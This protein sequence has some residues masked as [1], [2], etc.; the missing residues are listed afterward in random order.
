MQLASGDGPLFS[1]DRT[2]CIR[3]D[4]GDPFAAL[5]ASVRAELPH[6]AGESRCPR[7]LGE[8]GPPREDDPRW[9]ALGTIRR[10]RSGSPSFGWNQLP[11]FG[12][13][14]SVQR[15]EEPRRVTCIGI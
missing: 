6:A 4:G 7:A 3:I 9:L 12:G 1:P 11:G 13:L 8:I 2:L 14:C 10:D 15:R 5:L